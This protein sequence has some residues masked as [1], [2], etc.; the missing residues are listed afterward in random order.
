METQKHPKKANLPQDWHKA[1]IKAALE[2]AGWTLRRLSVHHGYCE[3]SLKKALRVPYPKAEGIIADALGL[4]P[5][6]I[7]PS[8]YDERRPLR[9][10]G[11]A[12]THKTGPFASA[13]NMAQAKNKGN[14]KSGMGK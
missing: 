13:K 11:G 5:K 6:V 9:G 7:W 1:D 10:V 4:K 3:G 2:K 12:H 8:R 14:Q